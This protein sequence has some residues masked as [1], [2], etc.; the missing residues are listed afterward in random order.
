M[1]VSRTHVLDAPI[2]ACWAMLHSPDSHVAKFAA[3]GHRELQVVDCELE[4]DRLRIVIER[5]VDVEVPAFA[6][7]VIQPTN[8]VRSV[9]EWVRKDPTTC[10]GTFVLSTKGVPLE[11]GGTT[12]LCADGD[13]CTY[14]IDVEVDVRV[15]I[16]GG[17]IAEV[18]RGIVDRQLDD[19]FH[20]A[21]VWLA[22]H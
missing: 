11:I 20:L 12:L 5:L 21:D 14:R 1:L 10:T 16:I 18:A 8:R 7:K 15:P 13:R 19:E 9:D 4:E 17:R 6:R 22:E 3:M 2:D